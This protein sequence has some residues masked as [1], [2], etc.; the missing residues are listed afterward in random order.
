MGHGELSAN[1][2]EMPAETDITVGLLK[3]TI[4][5]PRIETATE[6]VTIATGGSTERAIAQAYAQLILWMESDYQWDRW[7]AYDLLTHAGRISIGY[8]AS[9]AV[10]VKVEKRYLLKG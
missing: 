5:G 7:Q 2:L 3:R 6:I 1:G 8:Y 4:P 10:G 9:G